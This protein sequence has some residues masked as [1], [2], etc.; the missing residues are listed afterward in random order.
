MI[1]WLHSRG[2]LPSTLR[3]VLYFIPYTGGT[4]IGTRAQSVQAFIW[5]LLSS[6]T[7]ACETPNTLV[8]FGQADEHVH[9]FQFINA[10]L[11]SAGALYA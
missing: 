7:E 1:F 9:N 11:T 10:S 5:C 2:I 3:N 8:Y 6:W 4:V